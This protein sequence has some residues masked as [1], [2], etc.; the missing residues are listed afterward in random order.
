M[1]RMEQRIFRTKAVQAERA[2]Q[3]PVYVFNKLGPYSF[4]NKTIILYRFQNRRNRYCKQ[5]VR[6]YTHISGPFAISTLR[7]MIRHCAAICIPEEFFKLRTNLI[8]NAVVRTRFFVISCHALNLCTNTQCSKPQSLNIISTVSPRRKRLI[9]A[10]TRIHPGICVTMHQ[11]SVSVAARVFSIQSNFYSFPKLIQNLNITR[12]LN[13]FPQRTYKPKRSVYSIINNIVFIAVAIRNSTVRRT[14][15]LYILE[16]SKPKKNILCLFKAAVCKQRTA[17]RNKS[18]ASPVIPEPR[19]S[20][21]NTTVTAAMIFN[22]KLPRT[23][24]RP[25][26]SLIKFAVT[27]IKSKFIKKSIN[28]LFVRFNSLSFY[29][30]QNF[31]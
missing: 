19:K 31:L 26:N 28:L 18:I 7:Q 17:Q 14:F 1:L 10:Y 27:T 3:L 20:R 21:P 25:L 22:S 5:L 9:A 29:K 23:K 12:I 16:S 15:R 24:P 4:I 6:T 11:K 8:R 2:Y 13:I 30:T